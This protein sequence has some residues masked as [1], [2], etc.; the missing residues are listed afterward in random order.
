M[1]SLH[2]K[3]IAGNVKLR[4]KKFLMLRCKCCWV[5]DFRQREIDRQTKRELVALGFRFAR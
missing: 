3:G 5:Q 4:G 2:R 1:K